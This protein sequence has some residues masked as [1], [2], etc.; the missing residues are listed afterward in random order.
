MPD[1]HGIALT[2]ILPSSGNLLDI[3][4]MAMCE[5]GFHHSFNTPVTLEYLIEKMDIEKHV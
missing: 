2:P 3:K 1:D 5:C 4:I